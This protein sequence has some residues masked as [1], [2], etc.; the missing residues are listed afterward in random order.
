MFALGDEVIGN[1]ALATFAA[2]GSFAMLLLVDFGGPDA[3]SAAGAGRAG[4]D[5]RRVRLP[6]RR[7]PRA[8]VAIAA[9]RDGARRPS[10][11]LRRRRQL[12][13]RRGDDLAAA[14]LHPARLAARAGFLVPDRA[15]RLGPG[16][17]R[18]AASRSR[19]CGRRPRATP[20]ASA[21]IAACRALARDCAPRSHRTRGDAESL[22]RP[23]TRRAIAGAEAAVAALRR[24]FF[25]T[26]FRPTGLSTAARAVVRLVD[27][28]QLAA[29]AI[30][31][32]VV[33]PPAARRVD[34]PRAVR[35]QAAAAAS[36]ERG[37][38]AARRARRRRPTRCT[39]RVAELRGA[40]RARARAIADAARPRSAPGATRRGAR[41]R[42]LISRA[43]PELPRA[44]ARAIV[45]ARSRRTSTSP[46]PPS[47]AAGSTAARPPAA[48]VSPA[49]CPPP[50]S[51]PARTSSC[52]RSGCTTACAAPS[53]SGSPCSSPTLTGVQHSFWVVLG[54]LS[55]LRSNALS[56][57]QNVA[58]RPARH[59]R[60]LRRRRPARRADRRR[61]RRCSGSCCPSR[62]CSPAWRPPRSA[63]P[64]GR[65]RSR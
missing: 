60:R 26:P 43:R 20:S 21:A 64:P 16:L 35:G 58:P 8:R 45:V 57:G 49:P 34:A 32:A 14:R 63:S 36:L 9:R 2:F 65:P 18:G 27:E 41:R 62:S 23:S 44:G 56:T 31:V 12:G 19:C 28:L 15:R 3:R 29:D 4:G 1:P 17:G 55:V 13:A 42:Q 59:R 22:A 47:G 54:T 61:T 30:V 52:T 24:V 7:S 10:R 39:R 33:S 50:R 5:R 6:R 51:A 40:A 48:G 11:D 25:A 38:R 37:R 53:P 46:R